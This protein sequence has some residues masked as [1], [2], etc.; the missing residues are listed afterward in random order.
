MKKNIEMPEVKVIELEVKDI[1]TTSPGDQGDFGGEG[2]REVQ[3][4]RSVFED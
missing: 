2:S 4:R 1:V 3:E